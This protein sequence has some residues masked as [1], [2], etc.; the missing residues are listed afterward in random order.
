MSR[1]A[2]YFYSFDWGF[3]ALARFSGT[4]VSEDDVAIAALFAGGVAKVGD[5]GAA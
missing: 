2:A 3:A 4:A 1:A 5:R